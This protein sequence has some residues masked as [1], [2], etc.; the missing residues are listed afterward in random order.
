MWVASSDHAIRIYDT[1]SFHL[2]REVCTFVCLSAFTAQFSLYCFVA[3]HNG[4]V[5]CL[6]RAGAVTFSA[7]GDATLRAWDSEVHTCTYC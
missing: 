7:S 2:L 6:L 3:L 4:P 1:E 5:T